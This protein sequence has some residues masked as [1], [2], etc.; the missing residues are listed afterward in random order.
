M[1]FIECWKKAKQLLKEEA[2][3]K[4][5]IRKLELANLDYEALQRMVNNVSANQIEIEITNIEGIKIIIRPTIENE[6]GYKSF[7]DKY[8][9]RKMTK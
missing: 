2:Q 7:L 9:E 6:I 8:N 1:K 3:L 5:D 4:R